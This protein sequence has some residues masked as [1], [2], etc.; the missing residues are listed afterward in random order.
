VA[1]DVPFDFAAI[2][3]LVHRIDFYERAWE[4]FFRA[5][6]VRPLM[7]VYEDFAAGYEPTVRGV[8]DFLGQ[9]DP[10]LGVSAPA[11]QPQANDRS[12]E[13]EQRYRVQAGA[14]GPH[15]RLAA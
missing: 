6:D 8:L 9:S 13:W 3:R 10:G 4:A 11:L 1:V 12:R 7:I 2:D 15:R 5:Y 14:A